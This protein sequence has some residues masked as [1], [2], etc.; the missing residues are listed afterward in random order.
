MTLVPYQML[1]NSCSV[2]SKD[3]NVFLQVG[4]ISKLIM[5]SDVDPFYELVHRLV[6]YDQI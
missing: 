1:Y 2:K 6:W 3:K 4:F 5:N